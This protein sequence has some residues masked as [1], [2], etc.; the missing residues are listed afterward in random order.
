MGI[1]LYSLSLLKMSIK[2]E[3]QLSSNHVDAAIGWMLK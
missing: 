3:I 2:E 1:L